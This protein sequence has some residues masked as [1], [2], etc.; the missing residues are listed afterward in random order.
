MVLMATLTACINQ[1]GKDAHPE[2]PEFPQ[3]TA[4]RLVVQKLFDHCQEIYYNDVAIVAYTGDTMIIYDLKNDRTKR[5]PAESFAYI[6]G[7]FVT[8]D[9]G[10]I[11]QGW[12]QVRFEGH[13]LRVID[14]GPRFRS[15]AD[16][17]S[18]VYAKSGDDGGAITD[19][20]FNHYFYTRYRLHKDS[21]P[22][23]VQVDADDFY[24]KTPEGLCIFLNIP[25]C[26]E[27]AISPAV[28]RKP[29]V[30]S[31]VKPQ[32]QKVPAGG[33]SSSRFKKFDYAMMRKH[34]TSGGGSNHYVG[35]LPVFAEYGYYYYEFLVG[36]I[37]G[38][39]KIPGNSDPFFDLATIS[40]GQFLTTRGGSIYRVS[41][42]P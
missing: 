39:F 14:E 29:R 1:T 22:F 6:E 27:A 26:L 35:A 17:I 9:T 32:L 13:P 25:Y 40:P 23:T 7:Y 3:T 41:V 42:K 24:I 11:Y 28:I 33:P 8:K 19:S 2:L 36:N 21:I 4:S 34:W 20:L 12:D 31:A 38:K 30:Q 37:S 16:S 5:I 15:I 18:A 10:N